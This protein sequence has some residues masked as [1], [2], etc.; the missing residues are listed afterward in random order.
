MSQSNSLM[1]DNVDMLGTLLGNTVKGAVSEGMFERIETI[2]KLSKASHKGDEEAHK[3]LVKTLQNLP[4]DEFL[5][6]AQAFNQFLNL[7]NTAEQYD[8]ISQHAGGKENPVNFPKIYELLKSHGIGDAEIKKAIDNI[9]MDLVLT[10]HPTEIN[11]RSLINNLNEVSECLQQLDHDDI[12]DYQKYQIMRR[13]RQLCVQYWFTSDIR[14]NRPTPNEE[15][16]WGYD[17]IE[18]SLWD[19]IP[20]FIRELN[21][22]MMATIGYRIP[23]EARP[24]HFTSWMG[25]IYRMAGGGQENAEKD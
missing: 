13:L 21:E 25:R 24:V 15:A 8:T 6:V 20:K 18:N 3:K 17:V 1:R 14:K 4:D 5:P 12:V 22:Q 2:R 7:T 23:V 10:A 19:A 16:K 9:S 11:R